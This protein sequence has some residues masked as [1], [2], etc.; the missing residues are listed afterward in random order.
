MMPRTST[1]AGKKR[2]GEVSEWQPTDKP[3]LDLYRPPGRPSNPPTWQDIEQLALHYPRP[4]IL[5]E[6]PQ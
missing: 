4:F 6:P 2:V 1:R 3:N 5:P